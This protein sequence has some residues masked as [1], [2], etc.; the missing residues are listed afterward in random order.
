MA[1]ILRDFKHVS[2][3]RTY[4]KRIDSLEPAGPVTAWSHQRI[5]PKDLPGAWPPASEDKSSSCDTEATEGGGRGKDTSGRPIRPLNVITRFRVGEDNELTL[6]VK[7]PPSWDEKTVAEAVVKPFVAEYD[8]RHP[9]SPASVHAPF[10]RVKVL[11]WAGPIPSAADTFRPKDRDLIEDITI[12]EQP[13]HCL[14]DTDELVAKLRDRGHN[15]LR[16][17]VELELIAAESTALI[18]RT[19]PSTAL[20]APGEQLMAML[21]DTA[22]D[23]EEMH[24]LVDAAIAGGELAYL[25]LTTARDRHG[26]NCL[27]L[28]AT[29]GDATL[30]RKLLQRRED[31]YAMDDDRN[32]P[33]HIAALAGRQLIIRDL[34]ELG[35]CIHEKN[36][37]LM[38]PLN[39][40][41]VDEAQGN[42]EVVR[43]LVESGA[44]ID[45]KCWDITPIMAAAS[46]GHHWAIETLLEL[47]ADVN[48]R[49]GYEMMALDYAR[50]QDTADLLYDVMRGFFLPDPKMVAEQ[51][52]SRKRRQQNAKMFG[53]FNFEGMEGVNMAGMGMPGM[54]EDGKEKGPRLFQAQRKMALPQAFSSLEINPDWLE[55]FKA[56]GEHYSQIRYVWR[57]A[58]LKF[59]PDRQPANQSEEQATHTTS[60]YMKAM[61]AFESI[62]NFYALNHAKPVESLKPDA[63][64]DPKQYAPKEPEGVSPRPTGAETKADSAEAPASKPKG[65]AGASDGSGEEIST[66]QPDPAKTAPILEPKLGASQNAKEAT[67]R[68]KAPLFLRRRVTVVGL[69]AKPEFNGK[70]GLVTQFDRSK[71]RYKVELDSKEGTLQ[72]RVA[73]LK[74]IDHE[75]ETI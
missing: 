52:A 50:D 61:A 70:C 71:G 17:T 7:L 14:L 63:P 67:A 9:E 65:E 69:Q 44:D 51:E 41:V 42:G 16:P 58:V 4:T 11:V 43:M 3:Y 72:V 24:K 27:H 21:Q 34:L 12:A 66:S 10:T 5:P 19:T 55:G 54:G 59:H 31:V 8:R 45:S 28:A 60:E 53:G 15:H 35:C 1:G 2:K 22:T 30:C 18:L 29:R 6:R 74:V 33:V 48:I 36:R 57:Q 23:P 64:P 75:Q 40:A 38:L 68:A 56:T 20:L 62:D 73:N 39:L 32:M 26:K 49:N 46:G 13:I 47:G 37:D 25:G